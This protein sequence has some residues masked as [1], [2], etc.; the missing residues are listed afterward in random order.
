MKRK[1]NIVFST[2]EFVR[3]A[4]E[5]DRR[6]CWN[7]AKVVRV[8]WAG[9]SHERLLYDAGRQHAMFS[10]PKPYPPTPRYVPMQEYMHRISVGSCGVDLWPKDWRKQHNGN[11]KAANSPRRGEEE[12]K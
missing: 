8:T 6:G 12:G 5:L 2:A 3:K 7:G 10:F 11:G 9:V 1:G 4:N